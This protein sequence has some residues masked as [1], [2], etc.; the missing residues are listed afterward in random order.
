M[1]E[2]S[3]IPDDKGRQHGQRRQ[4]ARHGCLQQRPDVDAPDGG[5]GEDQGHGQRAVLLGDHG[6]THQQAHEQKPPAVGGQQCRE[7]KRQHRKVVVAEHR[8]QRVTRDQEEGAGG[9]PPGRAGKQGDE[10]PPDD[11]GGDQQVHPLVPPTGE[12]ANRLERQ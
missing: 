3:G 6:E 1:D 4:P 9:D 11:G 5:P 10:Q 8:D 2:R 12:P 7:D